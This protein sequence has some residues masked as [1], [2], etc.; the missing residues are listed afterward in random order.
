[1]DIQFAG[2][3]ATFQEITGSKKADLRFGVGLNHEFYMYTKSDGK[4][5]KVKDCSR[6]KKA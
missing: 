1:L 3:T 4:I 5:W 6:Q 2:K